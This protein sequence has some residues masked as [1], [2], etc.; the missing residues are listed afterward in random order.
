[1]QQKDAEVRYKVMNENCWLH[2]P[3]QMPTATMADMMGIKE[4]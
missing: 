1:V 3:N 2:N 4:E